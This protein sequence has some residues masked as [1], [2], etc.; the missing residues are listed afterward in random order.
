MK[1]EWGEGY[2][3][4]KEIL[5]QKGK[6]KVYVVALSSTLRKSSVRG[7]KKCITSKKKSLAALW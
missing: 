4:L 7:F 2:H 3:I 1:G 6:K 5:V